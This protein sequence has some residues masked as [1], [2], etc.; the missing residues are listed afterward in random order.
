MIPLLLLP[1]FGTTI[2]SRDQS[3]QREGK[4][5]STI[6]EGKR[7]IGFYSFIIPSLKFNDTQKSAR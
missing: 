2:V 1:A 7:I 6:A 4:H 5:M 3:D